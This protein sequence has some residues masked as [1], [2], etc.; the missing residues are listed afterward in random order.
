MAKDNRRGLKKK[1]R[2][3]KGVRLDQLGVRVKGARREDGE[4]KLQGG[5][6]CYCCCSDQRPRYLV[7]KMVMVFGVFG[8]GK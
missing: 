6:C 8:L 3:G 7:I 1:T 2:E 4:D 5:P